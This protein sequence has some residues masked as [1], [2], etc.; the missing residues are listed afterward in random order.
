VAFITPTSFLAGQ[1][2]KNLRKLLGQKAPPVSFAFISAR[3]N[4]FENVLRETML[5]VYHRAGNEVQGNVQVL[6]VVG[7][8]HLRVLPVGTFRLP[9][10][11]SEPWPLSRTQNQVHILRRTCSIPTRLHDLGFK[12][13]TGPLVWNRHK[14]QLRDEPGPGRYPLIWA[15]SVSA[16]GSFYFRAEKRGHKPYFQQD[17]DGT[18]HAALEFPNTDEAIT[19]TATDC[20]PKALPHGPQGATLAIPGSPDVCLALSRFV[21]ART[22]A[23]VLPDS[24][25]QSR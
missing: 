24:R 21:H 8:E 7:P 4:V 23:V 10:D 3:N 22:V 16:D 15:E 11:P 20:D 12:V 25:L 2:F 13:S 14:P 5:A 19:T 1:Y 17:K 18:D 6:D 9:P